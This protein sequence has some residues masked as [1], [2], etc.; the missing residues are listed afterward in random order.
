MA[1]V[2]RLDIMLACLVHDFG[3]GLTPRD[4]LPKHY[5]HDVKGV[6]VVEE[7]C[8]RLT[9]PV[10]IRDRSMK[11][12]RYHMVGHRLDQLNPKTFVKMFDDMGALND[13]EVLYLLFLVCVCDTRG[14][15]GS[16]TSSVDHLDK[17][18]DTFAA[19][20]SVKF[21][22]VFPAGETN[23]NKIKNGM[24]RARVQAVAKV[25]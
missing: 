1:P 8:N 20:R 7:F 18:L 12:T 17:L 25:A 4:Q 3:K 21:A 16:E 15:L 2:D 13:P 10:K 23:V 9:V 11:V 5:G 24:F 19:Y 22:N 6:P 14:R